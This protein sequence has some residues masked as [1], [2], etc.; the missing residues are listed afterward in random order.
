MSGFHEFLAI[1]KNPYAKQD[2]SQRYMQN[3]EGFDETY[4]TFCGT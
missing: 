1:L 2:V 4:Q 3:Q